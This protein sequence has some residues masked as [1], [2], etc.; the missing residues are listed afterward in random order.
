MLFM[1]YRKPAL[2]QPINWGVQFFF[3]FSFQ[4]NEPENLDQEIKKYFFL[5]ERNSRIKS[6]L[7]GQVHEIHSSE[8][9]QKP[10]ETLLGIC[11]FLGLTC[12]EKYLKDCSKIVYHKATRTRYNLVWTEKQKELI[13]K[14]LQEFPFLKDYRF[15]DWT[16][17][18]L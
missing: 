15:E 16:I 17:L 13:H 12:D 1:C 18:R 14:Q 5:A 10:Q 2:R 9:I 4:L 7:P 11:Q 3:N 8:M 6:L